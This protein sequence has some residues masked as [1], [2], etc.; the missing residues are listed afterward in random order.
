MDGWMEGRMDGGG[1]DGGG[2]DEWS[3]DKVLNCWYVK[4]RQQ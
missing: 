3:M 2:M 1:M 4:D